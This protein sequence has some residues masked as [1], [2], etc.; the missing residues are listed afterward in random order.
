MSIQHAPGSGY[1]SVEPAYSELLMKV[2][3]PDAQSIFENPKIQPW[4]SITERQNCVLDYDGG[5]LHIKRNQLGHKGV[6]KEIDGVRLLRLAGIKTVP[7][8]A[9]GRLHDGRGFFISH[10]MTP[11]EDSEK[12]LAAGT[13]FEKI[14]EPT[15][16]LAALLH[17]KKLHH[18][19]LYLCHFYTD[20]TSPMVNVALLDAGR[21]KKLPRFFSQRWIVKDLAQFI[22]STT[23]FSSITEEQRNHWLQ[24]YAGARGIRM[25]FRSSIDAKM[26]KIA[27]HDARLARKDPTRNV[28]I[29]R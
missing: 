14:L 16:N 2:G 12:L 4:R 29:D 3:L 22:Y 6:E 15:A 19:D 25:S 21:V 28:A 17:N 8:V 20:L 18:R 13:P 23:H 27:L 5:R 26:R 9:H 24:M 10:D 1:Y 7:V 11:F